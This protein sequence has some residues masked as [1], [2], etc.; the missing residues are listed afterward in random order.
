MVANAV[1]R[2]SAP[3]Q[4][5]V[6]DDNAVQDPGLRENLAR[7]LQPVLQ[8]LKNRF[9]ILL[10]FVLAYAPFGYMYLGAYQ[11]HTA[12]QDRIAEQE[13]VLALPEPRTDDI[14]SGL[15][16]WTAA[17]QTATEAQVLE[18][19]DSELIES[20]ISAAISV[21]VTIESLSTS[22]NTVIP[23]GE[24]IY[25]VTPVLMR[26]T[27]ELAAIESY[28][29]LLEDDAI[30]ALEIENS[31]VAPEEIGFS[32][33]VRALIFNRPVD[34]SEL[35]SEERESLSRRVTDEELDAAAQGIR[36]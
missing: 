20:L 13:A 34:P 30:E 12:L 4:R 21:G 5:S 10:L 6:S 11:D 17:L 29:S 8:H 33:T 19:D 14:E 2:P 1:G 15:R 18:L 31:L 35:A 3:Q 16:A 25:D 28:L 26:M 22:N 36:Q 7:Q 27:G 23:V 24:E 9:V 32:G